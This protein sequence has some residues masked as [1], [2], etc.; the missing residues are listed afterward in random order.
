MGRLCAC[1][2]NVPRV[3]LAHFLSHVGGI[4]SRM[5]VSQ[6]EAALLKLEQGCL[7]SLKSLSECPGGADENNSHTRS[8]MFQ[9]QLPRTTKKDLKLSRFPLHSCA[10]LVDRTL[11]EVQPSALEGLRNEIP[12]GGGPLLGARSFHRCGDFVQR[13]RVTLNTVSV[14][15][16]LPSSNLA[17]VPNLY[18]WLLD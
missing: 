7:R 5:N 1:R 9:T 12:F 17:F 8:N 18:T 14:N 11:D 6:R 15:L 10:A 16:P 4:M 13:P 2:C 3:M